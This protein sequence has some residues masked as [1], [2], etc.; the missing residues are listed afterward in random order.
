MSVY[1]NPPA[2]WWKVTCLPSPTNLE[3]WMTSSQAIVRRIKGMAL[4]QC[5]WPECGVP[6]CCGFPTCRKEPG[7]R[8][9]ASPRK[10]LM[11]CS[12]VWTRPRGDQPISPRGSAN[13][14]SSRAA[15]SP[16]ACSNIHS[17]HTWAR[18]EVFVTFVLRRS[19]RNGRLSANGRPSSAT[20]R[21]GSRQY[22]RPCY[23][24]P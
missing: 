3:R 1:F 5:S 15:A 9:T 12:L 7:Q 23:T 16:A 2:G 18:D 17:S 6:R 22:H 4:Q 20:A 10:L 24:S 14:A 8:A 19:T 13:P 11:E 21:R